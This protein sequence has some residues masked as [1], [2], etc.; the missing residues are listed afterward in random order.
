V[1][2]E[3]EVVSRR[4]GEGVAHESRRVDAKSCSHLSR[5]ALLGVSLGS[6]AARPELAK[7][8][9]ELKSHGVVQWGTY[10]S[11]DFCVSITAAMG[12]PKLDTGPQKSVWEISCQFSW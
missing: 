3:E 7:S 10:S 9:G 2:R 6:S 12:I 4:D 5:N 11:G 1:A 8:Q